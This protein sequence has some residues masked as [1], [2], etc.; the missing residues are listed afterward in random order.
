[1]SARGVSDSDTDGDRGSDGGVRGGRVALVTGAA[2]GMGAACA[3]K[4]AASG[5][6]LVLFDLQHDGLEALAGSLAADGA[7]GAGGARVRTVRGDVLAPQPGVDAAL[8]AFGRLDVVVNAA[9]ILQGGGALEIS[10]A[11]WDRVVGVNL[12]GAFLVSQC[13][14]RPMIDQG[15]GRIIHF[16]STAGKT[17]STLGGCHYT[18]AKHGVLGIVRSMAR[19]FAAHGVT[20]NAV[21]PGLIDTEMVR[22]QISPEQ[23]AEIART[24]PAGRLGGAGEVADLVA[25]LASPGSAYITGAAI[26]I[27]G[28]DLM[29]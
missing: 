2:Q 3:R 27:N 22:S 18:A 16:S 20:V 9:G 14:A 24:F 1:M 26:D 8:E 10:E 25:F 15:W 13:A 17:F 11:D 21:C 6:R 12:K 19:E 5:F 29:V 7:G 4:L 23:A 28:G